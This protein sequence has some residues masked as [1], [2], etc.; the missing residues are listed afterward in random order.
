LPILHVLD[1][2]NFTVRERLPLPENLAGRSI[3]SS[4]GETLYAASDSGAVILPIGSLDLVPRVVASR[5][6]VL[7][8]S[9]TCDSRAIHQEFEVTDPSGARTD[10][11]V[12]LDGSVSGVRVLQS[13]EL[14]RPSF[15]SKSIRRHFR[16]KEEPGR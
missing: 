7:I 8:R 14:R 10:F 9:S 3:L 2:D 1:A 16:T 6:D 4:D 12:R 13:S 11:A 5:E 15:G